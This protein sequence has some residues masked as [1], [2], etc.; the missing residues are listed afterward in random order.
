VLQKAIQVIKKKIPNLKIVGFHNG[1]FGDEEE[2][3]VEDIRQSGA[4]LLFV[5][6]SSPKK[7]NLINKWK[8]QFGV[9]FVMGIGGSLDV[10]S[11][12]I[13]RA[14][15]ILQITGLEWLFRVFQ[16][17][18]RMWKRYLL[19][20]L[21]FGWYLGVGAIQRYASKKSLKK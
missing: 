3:I 2:S 6:I 12:E 21:K 13:R 18:K 10:I 8:D 11:G 16:E 4:R 5:A 17:P 20:N 19:T 14:P 1:Y 7:E 9:D 15:A